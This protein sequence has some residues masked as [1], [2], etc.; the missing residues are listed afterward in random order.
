MVEEAKQNGIAEKTLRR[1]KRD[2][3]IVSR[4]EKE[5]LGEGRIG[6]TAFASDP[7]RAKLNQ[8]LVGHGVG[9]ARIALPVKPMLPA[10]AHAMVLGHAIEHGLVKGAEI[11]L[12]D[13]NCS[14]FGEGDWILPAMADEQAV[15]AGLSLHSGNRSSHR[16]SNCRH[17]CLFT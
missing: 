7:A 10:C 13:K 8:L 6:S 11:L 2:L 4:K 9:G 5:F 3:K 12:D 16:L 14:R 1:A 17:R 15:A